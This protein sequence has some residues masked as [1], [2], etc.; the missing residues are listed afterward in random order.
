MQFQYKREAHT[1]LYFMY[2]KRYSVAL[3]SHDAHSHLHSEYYSPIKI[4]TKFFLIVHLIVCCVCVCASHI[5]QVFFLQC[6]SEQI[7][8][9]IVII[10]DHI[11]HSY[12]NI[13]YRV[14]RKK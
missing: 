7:Q 8:Q 4:N 5:H 9:Q 12:E 11:T 6:L 3:I 14:W 2:G 13:H 1:R 10:I